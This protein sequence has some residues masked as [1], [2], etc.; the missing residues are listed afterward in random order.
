V[1]PGPAAL[2]WL[3]EVDGYEAL[4]VDAFGTVSTTPGWPR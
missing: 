1:A 4:V 2:P 3:T